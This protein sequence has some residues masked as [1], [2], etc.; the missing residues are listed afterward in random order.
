MKK[1]HK[2]ALV[3]ALVLAGFGMNSVAAAQGN[4]A[5][6]VAFMHD[7]YLLLNSGE[8][9][10]A[11]FDNDKNPHFL[12]Y[13]E[14]V[15]G[16]EDKVNLSPVP[17]AVTEIASWNL[18]SL[19]ATDGHYWAYSED[20]KS[21]IDFGLVPA[22]IVTECSDGK[23]ND[24]DGFVDLAD[25]GCEYSGDNSETNIVVEAEVVFDESADNPD[26]AT[27]EVH[28]TET[29]HGII[30]LV[31][32]IENEGNSSALL[33]S[34]PV[35]FTTSAEN[36]SSVVDKAYLYVDNQF[37]EGVNFSSIEGDHAIVLFDT[38]NFTLP[39]D[40]TF[41]FEVKADINS[42]EDGLTNGDTL[43]VSVTERNVSNSEITDINENPLPISSKIGHAD[44]SEA[45]FFAS[46]IIPELVDN[47]ITAYTNEDGEKIEADFQ[48][49]VDIIAIGGDAFIPNVSDLAFEYSIIKDGQ[50][51]KTGNSTTSISSTA[52]QEN[53]WFEIEEGYVENFDFTIN[54]NSSGKGFYKVVLSKIFWNENSSDQ[55]PNNFIDLNQSEYESDSILLN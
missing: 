22:Q 24:G 23:D 31:G 6:N 45:L 20:L 11:D 43:T 8:V 16:E 2:L 26:S 18:D 28:E 14:Y 44:G 19:L 47:D 30:L 7:S 55:S 32:E 3:C 37:V 41:N 1:I 36:L 54:V 33:S 4:G 51:I 49:E 39:E 50:E 21:W 9:L 35:T 5:G 13:A 10:Y 29:T 52:D 46:G 15:E 17:V 40:E 53:N 38:I 12:S 42:T 48:F 27:Y 25:I 34:L